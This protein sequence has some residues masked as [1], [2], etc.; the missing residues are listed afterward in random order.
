MQHRDIIVMGA[1]AGGLEVLREILRGLPEDLPASVFVVMH[2]SADSPGLLATVLGR[3]AELPVT[4]AKDGEKLR[5]AHIYVARPDHHLLVSEGRVRVLRGPKQNRHRPALD[6][7][8]RSAAVTYG[9]RVIGV[10]LTGNLDDGTA[11]LRAVKDRGGLAVVQDPRQAEFPG[12]PQSAV[13]HVE[14]DL[15]LPSSSIAAALTAAVREPVEGPAPAARPDLEIEVR[16]DSG[17]GHMEDMEAIGTPSVFA[18]PE[19]SGTLWEIGDPDLPRFRCR[20]GHAYTAESLVAQQDDYLED[21]LWAALRSLE[22]NV[23]LARRMSERFRRNPGTAS[24]AER[25]QRRAESHQRHANELRRLL[26]ERPA[27]DKVPQEEPTT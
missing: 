23:T 8:F 13:S 9:P 27:P 10:V 7:L 24:L 16:S 25:Y 18:C 2:M 11:G 5:R 20:V 12:M 21:A 4:E 3:D 15:Q 19:C 1:S 17:E 22:E 6:P 26:T 14:V